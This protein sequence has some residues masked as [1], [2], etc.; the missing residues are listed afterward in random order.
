[1]ISPQCGTCTSATSEDPNCSTFFE[2]QRFAI[3]GTATNG[4]RSVKLGRETKVVENDVSDAELTATIRAGV[5]GVN[6]K[7]SIGVLVTGAVALEGNGRFSGGRPAI[8]ILYQFDNDNTSPIAVITGQTV[9]LV[10]PPAKCTNGIDVCA[11]DHDCPGSQ[12]CE[13]RLTL[14]DPSNPNVIKTGMAAE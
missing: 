6:F 13:T 1:M 14:D 5:C 2:L 7:S 8:E 11:T 10:G 3:I 12:K 9:P 4:L